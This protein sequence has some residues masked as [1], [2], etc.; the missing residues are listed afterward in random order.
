MNIIDW[1]IVAILG[2]SVLIGFYRGFISSVASMGGG[3]VG[4][5]AIYWL[6]PKVVDFL[7]KNTSLSSTIS[8]YADAAIRAGD[9]TNA[10]VSEVA[11]NPDLISRV[12]SEVSLPA[13]L[14]SLLKSN[15]QNQTFLK[16]GINE[17]G[18]YVTNTIVGAVMNIICF[19]LCFI[20]LMI[21]FHIIINLLNHIFKFP[22]LKQLN[23]VAGGAFG[24]LRGVLLCFIA[25]ALLPLIQTIVPIKG[26]DELVSKSLLAPVFNSSNLILSIMRG[27]L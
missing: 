24:L 4:L 22:V 27:H 1:I 12:L 25:F 19:V 16:D 2:V 10:R 20:V 21:L 26:A 8:S 9:M 6:R 13:P 11:G 7:Q 15:L 5:G 3:L 17:V 14:D 18:G 23:S